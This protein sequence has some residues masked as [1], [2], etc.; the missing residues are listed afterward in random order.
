[1]SAKGSNADGRRRGRRP[2]GQ[3]IPRGRYNDEF[4]RTNLP[5]DVI[6]TNY[7]TVRDGKIVTLIIIA[8]E[9]AITP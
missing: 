3:T 7:F 6:L 5:D 4:H 8:S 2:H 9:P 1:V